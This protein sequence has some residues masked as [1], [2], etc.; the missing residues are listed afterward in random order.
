MCER[1]LTLPYSINVAIL[2]IFIFSSCG[3]SGDGSSVSDSGGNRKPIY[4]ASAC[5]PD[6]LNAISEANPEDTVYVPAGSCTW[7][8]KLTITKGINL[9]G[10]G[11]G[12]TIITNNYACT[13]NHDEG[14]IEYIPSD[15]SANYAF[16]LSGF[17]MDM[18]DKCTGVQLGYSK[19]QPFTIQTKIRIDHNRITNSTTLQKQAIKVWG[20]YGVI[21]HNIIDN[22]VYP[23][24]MNA[25]E[26]GDAGMTWWDNVTGIQFGTANNIYFEDNTIDIPVSHNVIAN[27]QYGGRYLFRYNTIT[28]HGDSYPLFDMHGNYDNSSMYSCFGGEVYGNQLNAGAYRADLLDQRGGMA[29]VLYNNITKTDKESYSQVREEFADSGA[30]TINPQPQHVSNSYYWI[31]RHNLTGSNIVTYEMEDCCNAIAEN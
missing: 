13:N 31:N 19:E 28:V 30:P 26:Y 22:I 15:Y 8:N 7:N 29:L 27:C 23:F 16:R 9:I 14:V 10:A 18:G 17:T 21:D 6:I 24:R 11:A 12:K 4:A 1:L 20:M 3:S 25:S 5:Y 2:S